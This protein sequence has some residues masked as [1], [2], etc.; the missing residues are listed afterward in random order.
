MPE[1]SDVLGNDGAQ[2]GLGQREQIR[3]PPRAQLGTLGHRLGVVLTVA[4]LLCDRGGVHL[5]E[6]QLHA[7][8]ACALSHAAC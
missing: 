1:V 5:V 3:I 8:A 7:S 2:L 4:Q 6:Q